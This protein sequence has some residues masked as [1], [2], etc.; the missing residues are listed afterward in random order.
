[1]DVPKDVIEEIADV[2]ASATR[3]GVRVDWLD[4][5][6]GRIASKKKHL[7]LLERMQALEEKLFELDPQRDEITQALPEIDAEMVTNNFSV[8]KSVRL[9]CEGVERR[10]VLIFCNLVI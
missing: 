6:L 8:E 1:M 7:D 3:R 10:T 2:T 4:E 5:V 9:P